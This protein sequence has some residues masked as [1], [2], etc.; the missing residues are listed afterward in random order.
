MPT[1]HILSN[2]NELLFKDYQQ[3]LLALAT[4]FDSYKDFN[5]LSDHPSALTVTKYPEGGINMI[6]NLLV[7]KDSG[8]LIGYYVIR[9]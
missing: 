3:D 5:H 6:A 2:D 9:G 8:D 1:I 4:L 7:D